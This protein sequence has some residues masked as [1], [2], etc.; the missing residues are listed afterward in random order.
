MADQSAS[1]A[2]LLG[3]PV[4]ALQ[5]TMARTYVGVVSTLFALSTLILALRLVSRWK[6]NRRLEA[7]DYFIVCASVS[8]NPLVP[9]RVPSCP[10]ELLTPLTIL[11]RRCRSSASLIWQQ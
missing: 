3:L 2:E 6:T 4:T 9:S 11:I 7:D 5:H 8:G 10:S 1:P